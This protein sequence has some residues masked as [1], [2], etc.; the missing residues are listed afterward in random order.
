MLDKKLPDRLLRYMYDS[1]VARFGHKTTNFE[2]SYLMTLGGDEIALHV[3]GIYTV[4]DGLTRSLVIDAA[5]E[6]ERRQLIEFGADGYRFWLT[7]SGFDEAAKSN[8]ARSVE[9]LNRNAGAMSVV[10]IAIS[11]VALFK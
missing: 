11:F 1:H 3:A 8:L 10:A 9:W 4:T 5:E 7:A 6:L 2:S